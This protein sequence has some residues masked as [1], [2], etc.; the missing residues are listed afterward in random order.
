MLSNKTKLMHYYTVRH[1]ATRVNR[2]AL[3]L[4]FPAG[5]IKGAQ[6]DDCDMQQKHTC[7]TP[8]NITLAQTTQLK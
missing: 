1:P 3:A 6:C 4:Q 8:K 2:V 5:A 7:I